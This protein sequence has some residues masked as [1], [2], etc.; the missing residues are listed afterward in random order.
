MRIHLSAHGL[1]LTAKLNAFV[2]DKLSHVE[3]LTDDIIGA[4]VVLVHDEGAKAP[5]KQYGVKVHLGVP[6]PDIHLEQY[7]R[8]LL[9]ATDKIVDKL[10]RQLRKRK[11]KL[12][13]KGRHKLQKKKERDKKFGS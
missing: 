3:H 2:A 6:G 5:T 8:D 10:A 1:K 13:E 7:D 11:T 12:K 4:H 9:A